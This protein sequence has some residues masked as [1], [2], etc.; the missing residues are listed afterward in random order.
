M[1]R[2]VLLAPIAGG[3]GAH[4]A[5]LLPEAFDQL[6]FACEIRCP[7]ECP[8]PEDLREGRELLEALTATMAAFGARVR[9]VPGAGLVGEWRGGQ[10]HADAALRAAL[11]VQAS[12][13]EWSR[14]AQAHRVT[15]GIGIVDSGGSS[16][17]AMQL[18]FRLS[19]LA[20]PDTALVC[21]ATYEGT[22]ERFD[23]R[24]L[25]PIVPR[26]DPLRELVFELVG[27][28]P[29]RSG[30]R[31]AGPE[32]APLIGRR[33]VL[34]ALDECRE[35]V[36][37]GQGVV[38]HLI[39]EPGS[40]KSKLLREWL[41]AADSAGHLFGWLRLD[42]DGVPY[43]GFPRRAWERL[44]TATR[45]HVKPARSSEDA[46][47]PVELRQWLETAG[48][49]AL[50]V[51]DDLHWVDGPSRGALAD[52]LRGLGELPALVVLAY[53]PSFAAAAPKEPAV[54]HRTLRL[55]GLTR[56]AIRAL[57]GKLATGLGFDLSLPRRE[58]IVAR[59]GGNPRY[60]HE[61]LAH[62]V[63]MADRSQSDP[64][65]S[66]LPDLLIRRIEWTLAHAL[67]ELER[68]H[69]EALFLEGMRFGAS[70]EREAILQRLDL[71]EER[72]ASWLDR[73]DVIEGEARLVV[74]A[75]LQGLDAI[76]GRLAL[77]SLLLGRQRPHCGR[78]AQA[79]GRLGAG[80]ESASSRGDS[81][82][83]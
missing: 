17:H 12:V 48:R 83:P 50:I 21:Q 34:R 7:T 2:R 65:P 19:S 70:L 61:A 64:L 45:E 68:R 28:K 80:R 67:P 10:R 62:L 77:L 53:R 29:E 3:H 5:S 22:R 47:T 41:A 30:S 72:L 26:S 78:L 55:S 58:E 33:G 56:P 40:G 4:D 32:R 16:G 13:R 60:A 81:V 25:T 46:L 69:R 6:V 54:L 11:A 63:D 71:L 79:L 27:P 18:A 35:R 15:F 52:L 44:A 14:A 51:V 37:G 23:Y 74:Q 38:V 66:S 39:G 31:H 36:E 20:N 59:A 82:A 8:S 76:D 1:E 75:F 24:G 43:G 42:T 49:P 9:V 57:L 73:L